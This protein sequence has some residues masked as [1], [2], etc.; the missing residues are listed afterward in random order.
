M[1]CKFFFED[2]LN[3][4]L[5]RFFVLE[6]NGS[7]GILGLPICLQ[8]YSAKISWNTGEVST[9]TIHP[10][11]IRPLPI[12]LNTICYQIGEEFLYKQ[13]TKNNKLCNNT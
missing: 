8:S 2:G 1:V 13:T 11:S 7:N 12:S 5:F 9:A 3:F 6:K 10:I 4:G